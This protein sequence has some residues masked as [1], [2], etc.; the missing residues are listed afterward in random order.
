[1]NNLIFGNAFDILSNIESNTIDLIVTDPPYHVNYQNATWDKKDEFYTNTEQWVKGCIRILK[2]HGSMWSFM[3][4][5]NVIPFIEICNKYATVQLDNWSIWARNKGRGSTKKLKSLREDIIHVTKHPKIHTWNKLSVCREVIAPYV[6]DGRPRGWILDNET[7]K[8]IRWTGLGN[9]FWYSAP[10]HNSIA[11]KQY[12]PCQKP[13]MLMQRLILLS[14]NPQEVVLDPFMGVGT[15]PIACITTNRNYI[16]IE[17]DPKWYNIA[18]DKIENLDITKFSQYNLWT[19]CQI[20]LK[21][22]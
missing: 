5:Q 2:P 13:V 9:V 1:M 17:N 7:G 18:K 11:E 8:R 19:D 21:K 14:S 20:D 15:T 12:H 22:F 3:S 4:Y 16:G 10:Q 6:K